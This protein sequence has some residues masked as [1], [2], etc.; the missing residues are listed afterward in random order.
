M[1][2]DIA[3]AVDSSEDVAL[4]CE[5]VASA[6][7]ARVLRQL[8]EA[9]YGDVRVSHGYIFQGVLAGDT[10]ITDL[11]K[12][13]GVSVQ[14]VSKSVIELEQAGY[15]HRRRSDDDGRARS[16]ELTRRGRSMLATSRRARA[17]IAADVTEV[18]GTRRTATLLASLRTIS[19]RLGTDEAVDDR[20]LRPPDAQL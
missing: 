9:G 11:A 7:A 4:W 3:D 12:R 6:S 5:V 13:L 8:E 16:I 20:R 1:N 2:A 10:T 18:L 15:L 14:A 17:E 19:T